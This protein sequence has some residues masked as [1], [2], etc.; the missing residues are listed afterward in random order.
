MKTISRPTYI[1]LSIALLAA[2]VSAAPQLQKDSRAARNRAPSQNNSPA[3]ATLQ[4][5]GYPSQLTNDEQQCKDGNCNN[6]KKKKNN[7]LVIKKKKPAV[8]QQQQATPSTP[9][10][11]Q[12]P[13][14]KK[15]SYTE[16]LANTKP[17]PFEELHTHLQS[18][19][20]HPSQSIY[21]HIER[22]S[23][24]IKY[25]NALSTTLKLMGNYTDGTK[26]G[27]PQWVGDLNAQSFETPD[28]AN[29]GS[30]LDLST[31]IPTLGQTQEGP[32]PPG[33]SN[34][35]HWLASLVHRRKMVL[36]NREYD[37]LS[38]E[39]RIDLLNDDDYCYNR[40]EC[41]LRGVTLDS[42]VR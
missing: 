7:N 42:F 10:Q 17:Q 4:N 16:Q 20:D 8:Q 1:I 36:K 33:T 9:K 2:V 18:F 19:I 15:L 37:V 24:N 6:N 32:P 12:I 21:K 39:C 40:G 23:I 28:Y 5:P 31:S 11:K 29:L 30:V 3:G 35:L 25:P 13:T 26:A 34:T 41:C 14:A 27:T 38:K 22:S